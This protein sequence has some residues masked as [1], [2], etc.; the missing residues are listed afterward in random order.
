MRGFFLVV[1]ALLVLA[2]GGLEIA[3]RHV[4]ETLQGPAPIGAGSRR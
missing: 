1:I 3:A 4:P 2:L